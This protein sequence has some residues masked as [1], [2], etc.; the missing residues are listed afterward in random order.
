MHIEVLI[1]LLFFSFSAVKLYTIAYYDLCQLT[2][3]CTF[4]LGA[5]TSS[6]AFKNCLYG[7]DQTLSLSCEGS[8]VTV[9]GDSVE[10]GDTC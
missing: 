2:I 3:F 10:S 1:R 6:R 4:L 5:I 9:R 8:D 7:V